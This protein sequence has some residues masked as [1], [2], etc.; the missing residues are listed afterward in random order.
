MSAIEAL[1]TEPILASLRG[2][3]TS[4]FDDDRGARHWPSMKNAE[5]FRLSTVLS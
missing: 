5:R 2:E 3:T 4:N 1:G